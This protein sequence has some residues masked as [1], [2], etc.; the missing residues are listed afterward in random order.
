MLQ[1]DVRGFTDR[2]RVESLDKREN[3]SA[4]MRAFV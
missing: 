2:N 4:M 1:T 3:T